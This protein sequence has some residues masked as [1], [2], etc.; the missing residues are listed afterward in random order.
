MQGSDVA[1]R[2]QRSIVVSAAL[3][4]IVI[5]TVVAVIS[6]VPHYNHLK[7]D[8]QRHLTSIATHRTLTI[9]QFFERAKDITAQIT[10]RSAL[11]T[12]L[13]T[14]NEGIISRNEL[15]DFSIPKI[16][17]ALEKSPEIL[18]MI[19]FD[20]SGTPVITV[21]MSVHPD[22]WPDIPP[23]LSNVEIYD[24]FYSE[25][26]PAIF[27]A[28]PIMNQTEQVGTDLVLF[29]ISRVRNIV[30]DTTGLSNY[31]HT[32]LG[33]L[34]DDH[35]TILFSLAQMPDSRA[36][37]VDTPT[38]SACQLAFAYGSGVLSA[39]S[40]D[41][42]DDWIIAYSV[43][44]QV[45][46]VIVI[47]EDTEVLYAPV[48]EQLALL[49]AIVLTLVLAGIMGITHLLRPLT[50]KIIIH[51]DELEREIDDKTAALQYELQE[52][53]RA[54]EELERIKHFNELILKAAG[55]GIFGLD[56][57]GLTT[58]VNPTALALLGYTFEDIIYKPHHEIVHH[59]RKD[60]STYPRSE[61]PISIA[62]T[63]GVACQIEEE[64]FWR[65]DG[66]P[67]PV[68]LTINPM[69][70]KNGSLVGAVV[71]FQDTTQ[72]KQAEEFLHT[73]KASAEAAAHAKSEFLA[74]MSHEIRT[75]M[76]AVIGMTTLLLD[77]RLSNEQR[78][79]VQT[80]HTS[81]NA[82]LGIIDD[83]LDFSKID[84]G[85]MELDYEPFDL[86]ACIEESLDL[87]APLA[88]DKHLDIMYTIDESIPTMLIGDMGRLR[89]V[90]VNLLNNGVKF[91]HQ[92]EVV[93]T[94]QRIYDQHT[95]F[96]STYRR[97]TGTYSPACAQL[98]PIP[99]EDLAP[100]PAIH[101]D[102]CTLAISIRDTGI[103]IPSDRMDRLFQSF[104]QTDSSMTRRY[105]GTGL[106]LAISKRL[107]EMMGGT[108]T[109]TSDE[110][111]GSTFT[112]ILEAHI[113]PVDK[114]PYAHL[115]T[116]HKELQDK[117]ILVVEDNETFRTILLH[118][119][120]QWGMK[121][122]CAASGNEAL[123]MLHTQGKFDAAFVDMSLRETNGMEL[124]RA[125]RTPVAEK[126]ESGD[127]SESISDMAEITIQRTTPDN[128]PLICMYSMQPAHTTL[129]ASN[130][131]FASFLTKP[132]K[133][134]VLYQALL[135]IFAIQAPKDHVLAQVQTESRMAQE[136]P[137]SILVVED[138]KVNQ[139][140][141]IRLLQRMGY[142]PDVTTNGVEAV[143]AIEHQSY[144]V[145]LM[146]IQMP[147]MDG[148]DATRHIRTHIPH[149]RQPYIVAMTAHALQEDRDLCLSVGMDD[150]V[151][152]PV[153]LQDLI[154]TLERV[155]QR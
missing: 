17:D 58:F 138:N 106:G 41:K 126:P 6:I 94:V 96:A 146:D 100:S 32:C 35:V 130:I 47:R 2:L 128:V 33:K 15:V 133:P 142:E 99:T 114:Q 73:A 66:T 22:M 50:G 62:V 150:Y 147:E 34:E 23:T 11:R 21:T 31:S 123:H 5:S 122:H 59:S 53:L 27:V 131:P 111:K 93:V 140:V 95:M 137:L 46:W 54:T 86:R 9:D 152:K 151:S 153:R 7:Q 49:V 52:R 76:N 18:G 139:K 19:R 75:P 136:H 115:Y 141:V 82:L 63:S 77:T 134:N 83:I 56:L 44:H 92:G 28:A 144:D 102:T 20:R 101:P 127:S 60:G 132:M 1:Q 88:A 3:G 24:P 10:S 29:D 13:E 79:F 80:I 39:D 108:I 104:S 42:D 51:T 71:T 149:T 4:I 84:A 125:I 116:T 87:M 12:K 74:N 81:S 113:A 67:L 154:Q 118:Q 129:Q 124:A 64:T 61:C 30:A 65:K 45:P 8:A 143:C 85:K 110:H 36:V 43:L 121:P 37:N 55:D 119:F 26:I 48:N 112:I 105:G 16:Q 57:Q 70:E 68:S 14:Y 40:L 135:D 97:D 155:R 89:Q 91:T 117:R 148:L 145:V 98:A 72:R 25:D 103:G 109:V 120:E 69:I 90:L 38:G 78:D 107:I